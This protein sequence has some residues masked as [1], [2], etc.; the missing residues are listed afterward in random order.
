MSRDADNLL[1]SNVAARLSVRYGADAT[2]AARRQ[3]RSDAVY[4]GAMQRARTVPDGAMPTT[5]GP[6]L[7]QAIAFYEEK[8][9]YSEIEIGTRWLDDHGIAQEV[10][11]ADLRAWRTEQ[12]RAYDA[13]QADDGRAA[14]VS[15]GSARSTAASP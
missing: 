14:A 11:A 9:R 13:R 3:Q 10:A 5:D 15:A 12:R 4:W 1:T 8:T 2:I 6:A 7:E